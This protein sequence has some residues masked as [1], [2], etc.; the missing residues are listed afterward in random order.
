MSY[1]HRTTGKSPCRRSAGRA[2]VEDG[3]GRPGDDDVDVGE[4][5]RLVEELGPVED[6]VVDTG[7]T[8]GL[9]HRQGGG[10]VSGGHGHPAADDPGQAS[11]RSPVA[12]ARTSS[13]L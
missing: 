1:G 3:F 2:A 6:G 10:P 5:A 12:P 9:E 13:S 4:H 8:K 7:F 11:L